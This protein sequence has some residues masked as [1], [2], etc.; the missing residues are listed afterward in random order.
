VFVGLPLDDAVRCVVGPSYDPHAR[1]NVIKMM[2][3]I[4]D[5]YEAASSFLIIGW[6]NLLSRFLNGCRIPLEDFEKLRAKTDPLNWI[7]INN[8]G[9]YV[10][11]SFSTISAKQSTSSFRHSASGC[12]LLLK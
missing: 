5:M 7:G 1:L 3:G 11:L 10:Q 8:N 6:F 4:E 12:I 2:A 9:C